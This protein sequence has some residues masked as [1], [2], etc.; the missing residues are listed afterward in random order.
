MRDLEFVDQNKVL[1][2]STFKY[3]METKCPI[4]VLMGFF[5]DNS[6]HGFTTSSF[7][8][9]KFGSYW[10]LELPGLWLR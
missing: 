4:S 3:K 7:N 6:P 2:R 9:M 5:S 10:K 1:I 8:F